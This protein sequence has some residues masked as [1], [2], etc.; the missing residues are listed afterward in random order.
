ML[1]TNDVDVNVD[2]ASLSLH[3]HSFD[4]SESDS[5]ILNDLRSGK[6]KH[7]EL[8][9]KFKPTKSIDL[10]RKHIEENLN[11]SLAQLPFKHYD[12]SWVNFLKFLLFITF[13]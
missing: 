2:I 13:K 9:S 11:L 10:R 8:E 7:R 6:L 4:K 12:F 5:L 1:A 3:Q